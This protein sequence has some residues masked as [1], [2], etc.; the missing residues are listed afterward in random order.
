MIHLKD[1]KTLTN[2]DCFPHETEVMAKLGYSPD[3]ITSVERVVDGRILTI[4]KSALV[5]DFFVAT[6]VGADMRMIPGPQPPPEITKRT[7]GCY[8]KDSDPP[9]QCNLVM[10]AK[11]YDVWLECYVVEKKTKKGINAR[12]KSPPKNALQEVYTKSLIGNAYSIVK[13]SV[14]KS[15]FNTPT[16]LGCLFKKPKIRAEM[17]IRSGN[18]LVEFMQPDQKLKIVE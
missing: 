16:G 15:V 9:V 13:T 1:G 14:I 12:R 8:L 11:S 7:L 2:A 10:N 3:D 18:V 6:D 4:K 17:L 5:E